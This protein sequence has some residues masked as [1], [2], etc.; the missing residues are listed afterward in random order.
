MNRNRRHLVAGSVGSFLYNDIIGKI[1]SRTIRHLYLR[2]YLGSLAKA[3]SVQM[4]CRFLHGKNVH[5]GKRVVANFGCL[6]DGRRYPIKIGD[7]VSIGPRASILT[8][9]HDPYSS[10]FSDKGGEVDVGDYVWIAYGCI[11]LPNVTIGR[12]AVIGAGAVVSKDVEPFS[13]MVGNPAQCI[14]KRPEDL[15]YELNYRPILT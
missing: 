15:A 5:I 7:N 2:W 6:F 3:S 9:G 12:G 14:G 1:P 8:L 13:I 11:I 4:H 10:E